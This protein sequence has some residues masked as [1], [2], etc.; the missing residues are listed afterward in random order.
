MLHPYMQT[1]TVARAH[2]NEEREKKTKKQHTYTNSM[3]SNVWTKK[4]TVELT[5]GIDSV[6][7]QLDLVVI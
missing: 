6:S 1:P 5:T 3:W 7:F 4:D 2:D